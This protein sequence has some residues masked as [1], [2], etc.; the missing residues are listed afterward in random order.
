MKTSIHYNQS[1]R[2]D[3]NN[4]EKGWKSNVYYVNLHVPEEEFKPFI[5]VLA[6]VAISGNGY[7]HNLL[8]Q[9]S[10]LMIRIKNDREYQNNK[11]E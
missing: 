7:A 1:E 8:M 6:N 3:K 10:Q 2:I 11:N 9:V 4:P 5:D